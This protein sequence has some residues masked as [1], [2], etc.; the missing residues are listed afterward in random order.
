MLSKDLNLLQNQKVKIQIQKLKTK[1]RRKEKHENKAKVGETEFSKI[2]NEV[3]LF[4][5]QK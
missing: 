2:Y 3:Q 4:H 5:F 1:N